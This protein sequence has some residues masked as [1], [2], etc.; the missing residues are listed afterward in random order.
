MHPTQYWWGLQSEATL[1]WILSNNINHVNI[2][3]QYLE[4]MS[5]LGPSQAGW[6]ELP[7]SGFEAS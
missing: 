2:S 6:P 1:Y 3:T 4:N 7:L 5:R